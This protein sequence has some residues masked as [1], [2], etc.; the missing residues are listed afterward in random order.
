MDPTLAEFVVDEGGEKSA[1]SSP[2]DA[3]GNR[4]WH[5]GRNNTGLIRISLWLGLVWEE[6]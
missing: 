1:I 5:C 4:R 6:G 2:I 3:P